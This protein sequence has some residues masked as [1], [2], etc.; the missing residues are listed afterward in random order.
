MTFSLPEP[1]ARR[2]RTAVPPRQ[3]SRLVARL[4]KRELAHLDQKLAAACVSANR[5]RPLERE[6]AEWQSF[7]DI[8]A[9][10]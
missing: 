6:T 10:P 9:R 1:T 7:D 5:D 3:R 4:L 2:F 8:P